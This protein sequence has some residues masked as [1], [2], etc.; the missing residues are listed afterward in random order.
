MSLASRSRASGG[1][2]D[3]Q[4]KEALPTR[5]GSLN[6]AVEMTE[7]PWRLG[8]D[9][10]VVSVDA[11][12]PGF[13]G[14]TISEALNLQLAES[15]FE[16]VT[17]E[18][19]KIVR[20][21]GTLPADANKLSAL[22]LATARERPLRASSQ[23]EGPATLGAV[24]R[25]TEAVL[26]QSASAGIRRLGLSLLGAGAAG[27][28]SIDVATTQAQIIARIAERGI[29]LTDIIFVCRDDQTRRL[30]NRAF[31]YRAIL[32]R[33]RTAVLASGPANDARVKGI[34]EEELRRALQTDD[35]TLWQACESKFAALRR[36][37]AELEER[38]AR[39]LG[40]PTDGYGAGYSMPTSEGVLGKVVGSIGTDRGWASSP[41]DVDAMLKTDRRWTELFANRERA[42]AQLEADLVEQS[43]VPILRTA[44]NDWLASQRVYTR[45][46]RR[47]AFALPLGVID[48][49][50]LRSEPIPDSVV[51]TSAH[52][53]LRMLTDP[54]ERTH[55]SVGVAGARGCGKT[56]V[57]R[58]LHDTW[59]S[60]VRVLAYAP[61]SYVPREFLLYLYG[62]VC[63]QVLARNAYGPVRDPAERE[64][65][66]RSQQRRFATVGVPLV[67]AALGFLGMVT[68]TAL[69]AAE[70]AL[71]LFGVAS[72]ISLVI[73]FL[74][75]A[76][77]RGATPASLMGRPGILLWWIRG[78]LYLAFPALER[79][80][81][82]AI[83]ACSAT[84]VG[85]GILSW[86]D[87]AVTGIALV[88]LSLFSAVLA[89]HRRPSDE[90]VAE[91]ELTKHAVAYLRVTSDPLMQPL[92]PDD[93]SAWNDPPASTPVRLQSP[94]GRGYLLAV[95]TGIAAVQVLMVV[96]GVAL[97]FGDSVEREWALAISTV[98]LGGGVA[99]LLAAVEIWSR[100]QLSA[101]RGFPPLDP[102]SVRAERQLARITSQ[103]SVMAGWSGTA[104]FAA[105]SWMPFGVDIG[106][107]GSTTEADVP[108]GVPEIIDGIKQML[109]VRGE[110]LVVID[111]LDKLE[112]VDKARA[113]LNEI[114]GILDA[115]HTRFLV[116]MSEDAIAS[117][118]RRGLPF[119]DVFDSSF[120]EVVRMP[121][122]APAEAD[123]LLKRKVLD[124]PP[125]YLALA[126]AQSGGLPR[127]LL[128]SLGRILAVPS[129]AGFASEVPRS[130][131]VR[132]VIH[133]DLAAK[134]DA[135]TGA[136]KSILIEPAA[137]S[138]LRAFYEMDT[139]QPVG[140]RSKPCL[141]DDDW[142][143]GFD[144]V[145]IFVPGDDSPD[146]PELRT[147]QR[148]AVELL[149][150]FYYCRTVLE[151]FV[152]D[153]QKSVDR[154]VDAVDEG[155]GR[156]L[157]QLAR[158]RQNFAVNPFVAW[159]QVSSLRSEQQ[160]GL[161]SFPVPRPLM[162]P[163]SAANSSAT[164]S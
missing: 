100:N 44:V 155:S 29:D 3:A 1:V 71:A 111:E 5:L 152:P 13:L 112:S 95:L 92:R 104:R 129:S 87:R 101:L 26:E 120:D 17:A 116:S 115:D 99:S 50:G 154:L 136:I 31:E 19:P 69:G 65:G 73:G 37:D 41:S 18:E 135:A 63:K 70:D 55:C 67:I 32:D 20:L 151:L 33:A 119:R 10:I 146:L 134:R 91:D 103:R 4:A 102:E 162:T 158:A 149:G 139:C 34:P 66:T 56:T 159:E 150:Y 113:F 84:I 11:S 57:L 77:T 49:S 7:T 124:V 80:A 160:I 8:I 90:A 47:R 25:A 30:V 85:A 109:P 126:Y 86:S 123:V 79:L 127:D 138:L 97:V 106:T 16:G 130:D 145:H 132:H 24:E 83:A 78:R 144:Q 6:V 40:T 153:D 148:L 39:V 147:L 81:V 82:A 52:D 141:L 64:E 89:L 98:V 107:T 54:S 53:Q 76:L 88:V 157:T 23:I 48:R 58:Q 27:L 35:R 43:L 96:V 121:Y 45:D 62:L 94:R 15:G 36:L 12:G 142:L 21:E 14:H 42:Q 93:W 9:A 137:S 110:A 68:W 125:A 117:F 161:A 51:R 105:S 60:G 164:R 118:E 22:I 108:L 72:L 46:E 75:A 38:R 28:A 156:I 2:Q 59:G 143:V 128:R 163:T 131:L 74:L 140:P 61:A 122:L 133:E 114:K